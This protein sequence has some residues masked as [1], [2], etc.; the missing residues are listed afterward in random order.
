VAAAHP[1]PADTGAFERRLAAAFI[2]GGDRTSQ[3]DAA[4]AVQQLVEVALRALSP[5]VNEPFTAI[6]CIDRLGQGLSRL[7][8]RAMPSPVRADDTG[9]MRVVAR[10]RT[11]AELLEEAFEPVARFAGGNP[12]IYA[13]LLTTLD[14][15]ATFARREQD[16][17]AIAREAAFVLA[18]AELEVKDERHRPA[19]AQL[20][21]AVRTRCA[22]DAPAPV[23]HAERT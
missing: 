8:V 14:S 6:T 3:Q 1:P 10:P 9:A 15:L 2:V 16:R 11:F 7:A 4:F 17:A 18:T 21:E 5:G 19:L 20:A 23:A 13:R 12:A 22:P